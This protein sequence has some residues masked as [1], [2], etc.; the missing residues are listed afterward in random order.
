MNI[1][2]ITNQKEKCHFCFIYLLHFPYSPPPP[3][4]PLRSPVLSTD[5]W[6][7]VFSVIGV[8]L[9]TRVFIVSVFT[10]RSPRG[11]TTAGSTSRVYH[12]L[13]NNNK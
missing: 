13:K 7:C 5:W 1:Y 11:E 10:D 8:T 12:V 6:S 2:R 9:T 3:P 4:P